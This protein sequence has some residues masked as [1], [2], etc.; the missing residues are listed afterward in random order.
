MSIISISGQQLL[1]AR[2][3]NQKQFIMDVSAMKKGIYLVKMQTNVG[4]ETK[5]LVIQ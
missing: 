3:Q 4:I 2:F 1:H 5:K